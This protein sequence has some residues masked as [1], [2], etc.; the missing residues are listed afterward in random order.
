MDFARQITQMFHDEHLVSSAI[1]RRFEAQLQTHRKGPP[2][3]PAEEAEFNRTLRDIEVLIS[4]ELIAHF[5]FEEESLFPLL[6]DAG[7]GDM[8]LLLAEEHETILGTAD[9]L[10]ALSR[11]A[12][13]GDLNEENW[14][15]MRRQGITFVELMDGH[16]QKEDMGMLPTLD[17]VIDETRDAELTMEYSAMR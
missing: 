9:F 1:L 6:T 17:N 2:T 3:D 15:D 8:G 11:S 4:S 7:E 10:V 12:Q 13:S 5:K 16:I 14:P